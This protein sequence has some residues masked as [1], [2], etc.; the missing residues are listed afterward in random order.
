[1]AI[2]TNKQ[3]VSDFLTKIWGRGSACTHSASVHQQQKDLL[4]LVKNDDE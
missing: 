2:L 3:H 1:M 4:G